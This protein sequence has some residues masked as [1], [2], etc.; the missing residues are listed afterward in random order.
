MVKCV[1]PD[2]KSGR[3][4]PF[5]GVRSASRGGPSMNR[6]RA[7]SL[8]ALTAVAALVLAACG[9]SSDNS[10]SSSAT[11]ASSANAGGSETA[12]TGGGATEGGTITYAQEQEW[13][14]YNT[15]SS[16]GGATAN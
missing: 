6:T 5:G 9:S 7:V 14:D 1:T 15:G 16:S 12:A 4:G 10:S 2:S 13:Y 11:S 3:W 8:T